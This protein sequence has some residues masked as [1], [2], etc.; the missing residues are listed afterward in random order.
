MK[1]P[2]SFKVLS[3]LQS[4]FS[5]ARRLSIV[6]ATVSIIA[7]GTVVLYC[8]DMIKKEREKIYVLDK[9]RS[10]IM[11]LQQDLSANRPVEARDHM[12]MF[13]EYFFTLTP[14]AALIKSN[15]SRAIDLADKSAYNYYQDFKEAG[16]YRRIVGA[17]IV[18]TMKVDSVVGDFDSYPYRLTTYGTQTITRDSRKTT[19]SLVTTCELINVA[20]S[21]KNPHGFLI[22]NFI[23]KSNTTKSNEAR[24]L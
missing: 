18:Q 4:T 1:K 10:L 14:D 6:V 17:N 12:R 19:R 24:T 7:S 20:R 22:Q 16:Y 21:D 23:I 13:H 15:I 9:G 8:L 11:A 3:N 2:T 5:F